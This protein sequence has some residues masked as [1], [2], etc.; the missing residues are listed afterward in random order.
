MPNIKKGEINRE[1]PIKSAKNPVGV[2]ILQV[3][4]SMLPMKV[5]VDF[6]RETSPEPNGYVPITSQRFLYQ[7][8]MYEGWIEKTWFT[9]YTSE[10]PT[11][12]EPPVIGLAR[13]Y[14]VSLSITGTI[15][16]IGEA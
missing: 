2:D 6:A 1:C 3:T 14:K 7:D 10:P 15:E 5:D 16:E 8:Q 13:K 4:L 12:P 9:E 11:P